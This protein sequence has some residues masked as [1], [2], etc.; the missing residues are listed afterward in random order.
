MAQGTLIRRPGLLVASPSY[1][2]QV[3]QLGAAIDFLADLA[4][5]FSSVSVSWLP[6]D[7]RPVLS[8]FW[9]PG[10]ASR[11]VVTADLHGSLR[12]WS[13]AKLLQV[14]PHSFNILNQVGRLPKPVCPSW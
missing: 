5:N 13:V 7:G 14:H 6:H 1:L 12:F 2:I 3:L 11:V 10:L 9:V 8:G 4:G